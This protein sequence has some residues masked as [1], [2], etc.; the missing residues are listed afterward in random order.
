MLL[1]AD[2]QRR[3]SMNSSAI[4]VFSSLALLCGVSTAQNSTPSTTTPSTQA[5]ASAHS[6]AQAETSSLRIAPGSVIPVQLTKSI[7]VKKAKSGDEVVARVTQDMKGGNGDV[8][9]PKDAKVMGHVTE[10]QKRSKEQ[11]ESQLGI[12][13][14]KLVMKSGGDVNVPMSIQ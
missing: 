11:K 4:A 7:D 13:F 10:A 12:A 6:A 5:P 1:F 8:V 2:A 3:N 14:D 9:V